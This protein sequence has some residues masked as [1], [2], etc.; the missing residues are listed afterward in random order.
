MLSKISNKKG[1][2]MV[3]LLVVLVIIAILAA[4]A[5]PIYLANT[6]RSKI[7][8]A[9][10][11]MGLVRQAE[12]DYKINHTSYFDVADDTAAP[13]NTSGNI[14][15][16]LPN[17]VVAATGVP[18]PDPSGVD[19]NVGVAQ[20][21]SNGS[22]FVEAPAPTNANTRSQLFVNPAPVDFLIS[23]KGDGSF[24][25]AAAGNTNCAV[26]AGDVAG[27]ELEMDNSGRIFVCYGTC[28]TAANWS[29]Y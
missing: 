24:Q 11:T 22:F 29:A 15:K 13:S 16:P 25:C 21:F 27:Y 26:H 7:S 17:S 5:T 6:K 28:G 18:T 1:F 23:A 9:I 10:A 2:T 3:E 8:E 14:Q 20:Y 12:R 19:V 4:V